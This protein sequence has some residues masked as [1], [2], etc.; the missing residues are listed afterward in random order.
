[1]GPLHARMFIVLLWSYVV[2][3]LGA[4]LHCLNLANGIYAAD[5]LMAQEGL[6]P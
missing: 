2:A 1:M 4:F 6:L 5:L 3:H